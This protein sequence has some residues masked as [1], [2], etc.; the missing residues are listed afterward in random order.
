MAD[1]NLS[2]AI[3]LQ[4]ADKAV[5]N[6]KKEIQKGF[7][8]PLEIDSIGAAKKAIKK[9]QK[10]ADNT[11]IVVP[12]T[13]KN[14]KAKDQYE[15]IKKKLKPIQLDVA[16]DPKSVRANITTAKLNEILGAKKVKVLV[17]A[18]FDKASAKKLKSIENNINTLTKQAE[19]LQAVLDKAN[20]ASSTGP[21][22]SA[23]QPKGS[24]TKV[25]TE[26]KEEI[27]DLLNTT[28]KL[29]ILNN[30]IFGGSKSFGGGFFQFATKEING[31][32]VQLNKLS[33]GT[34]GLDLLAQKF[35]GLDGQSKGNLLNSLKTLFKGYSDLDIQQKKVVETGKK[36]GPSFN[37]KP[38][39]DLIKQAKQEIGKLFLAFD[40]ADPQTFAISMNSSL[41]KAR[42]GVSE[43]VGSSRRDIKDYE[44]LLSQLSQKQASALAAKARPETI[45]EIQN[46]IDHVKTEKI[47]GKSTESIKGGGTFQA[48]NALTG[49]FK[50]VDI[51]A[52]R[53]GASIDSVISKVSKGELKNSAIGKIL[54]L[55]GGTKSIG[56]SAGA[57]IA[58]TTDPRDI[59]KIKVGAQQDANAL[60]QR[61]DGVNRQFKR[62][63]SQIAQFEA[64]NFDG[65]AKS[66]KGFYSQFIKLAK[67]GTSIDDI[68]LAITKR[69]AQAVNVKGLDVKVNTAIKQIDRLKYA[70]NSSPTEDTIGAKK[71]LD[72]LESE[73]KLRKGKFANLTPEKLNTNLANGIFDIRA[74]Q[75]FNE[76]VD[77]TASKLR[78]IGD[79]NENL[80]VGQIY[81]KHA[82]EFEN[83]AKKIAGNSDNIGQKLRQLKNTADDT[84]IK[85]KFDAEGGFLGSVAKSA[86][87][88]TK[89]L[90]AFLVL[91]QGLYTVQAFLTSA[92]SDALKIDKEF[93]RLEQVFNKDFSGT[94]LEKTLTSVNKQILNLGKSLGVSTLEVA[95][96]AQTLAQAGIAGR[97]LEKLLGTISKSQLGP[98]FGNAGE[99]A[100]AT[101]AI[102]N[103]FKLSAEGV[104]AALGGINRVSAKYAVEAKGI[105]EAVRRAGG[106]F[107]TGGD[108]IASFTAAFT[109]VKQKTREADE[110][111]STGLRNVAQRLQTSKVQEKLKS[112]LG[113]DLVENGEFIGFERSIE[114]IGSAL[115]RLGATS[116]SPLFSQIRELIGGARQGGRVTPLL[117]DYKDFS[118]I[119]DQFSKGANSIEED[120]TTAF[121]SIE[122]K[123]QRAK[124]AIEALYVEL[125]R[126][127]FVTSL[128]EAFVQVTQFAT[129][130]LSVLNSV[131]GAILAI[132]AAA[133]V[134]SNSRFIGQALVSQIIPRTS[135]F[136]KN[137]GGK[138]PGRGPNKDSLLAALTPGEF[139]VSREATD[140][141]GEGFL[142]KINNRQF[143]RGGVVGFNKGGFTDKIRDVQGQIAVKTKEVANQGS[144][145]PKEL[146][147]ELSLLRRTLLSLMKQEQGLQAS[148]DTSAKVYDTSKVN[149]GAGGAN[150]A[151]AS[152][153]RNKSVIPAT[154]SR[155]T[156]E[157][158]VGDIGDH[159][160]ARSTFFDPSFVPKKT[161]SLA[162]V[163]LTAKLPTKA[164]GDLGKTVIS[165][166]GGLI[167]LVTGFAAVQGVLGQFGGGL[168]ELVTA[169]ASA[170]FS[171]YTFA[172]AGQAITFAK[173]ALGAGSKAIK[174]A[175]G[176]AVAAQFAEGNG[177]RVAAA[178]AYKASRVV[179]PGTGP[180]LDTASIIAKV[181]SAPRLPSAIGAGGRSAGAL[182]NSALA[183]QGTTISSAVKAFAGSAK[184]YASGLKAA[185]GGFNLA[186]IAVGLF[187]GAMSYF[188]DSME[189]AGREGAVTAKTLEES[190]SAASKRRFGESTKGAASL[191]GKVGAGAA[192]GG[193]LGSVVPVVGTAIGA[194]G[195]ALAAGLLHFGDDISEMFKGTLPQI[196]QLGVNIKSGV[197]SLFDNISDAL[198]VASENFKGGSFTD[199]I[200]SVS[201]L[202]NVDTYTG[203]G[204]GATYGDKILD[205]Q[206]KKDDLDFRTRQVA[207]RFVSDRNAKNPQ[208]FTNENLKDV[209]DQGLYGV[210]LLKGVREKKGQSFNFADFAEKDQEKIKDSLQLVA[211]AYREAGPKNRQ[212]ILAAYE[213]EG[214]DIK[215][216]A[217]EVGIEIDSAGDDMKHAFDELSSFFA[218]MRNAVELSSARLSGIEGAIAQFSDP[219]K[220][221]FAPDQLFDIL[222]S[223]I[224][225]SKLG[226]GNTFNAGAQRAEGL[227]NQ[228]DPRLAAAGNFE[229]QGRRAARNTAIAINSGAAPQLKKADEGNIDSFLG[230]AFSAGNGGNAD[231]DQ[232]FGKFL[233]SKSADDKSKL[234]YADG[235]GI[236]INQNEI[237]NLFKEFADT[238]ENGALEEIKR[239]NTVSKQFADEY[240]SQLAQRF[241]LEGEAIGLLQS[242]VE[243]RKSI[244]E[245]GNRARGLTGDALAGA[246]KGQAAAS[247]SQRLGLA[248]RGTGL[249]GNANAGQLQAALL[250]SQQ[251]QRNAGV[252]AQQGGGG[253]AAIVK[254]EAE[255]QAAETERQNRIRS[256][257][258]LLAGD[259]DSFTHAMNEFERASQKAAASS[260]FLSDALLGSDDQMHQSILGIQ[261]MA[262]I[263]EAYRKGG[264]G[265]A[266][267]TL[268]TFSEDAR[269]ALQARAGSSEENQ[270]AFNKAVGIS[271]NIQA[272]PE[273]AAAQGAVQ[274]Q[275]E[276]NNALVAGINNNVVALATN[277]ANMEKF[278]A[279]QFANTQ[280]IV[281]Q[282]EASAKALVG[283]IANLPQTIQHEGNINVNITGAAGLETLQKGISDYV[284]QMI[285]RDIEKLTNKLVENNAGLNR[286]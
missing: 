196:H 80:G 228:F 85:A 106:V 195:G 84:L 58:G 199:K 78:N 236:T 151:Y 152:F 116:K 137:N 38:Q 156:K 176:K 69:I 208:Q 27:E 53:A 134:L 210:G 164:F 66:L 82:A 79:A 136:G 255:I 86:G 71:A 129:R 273:A 74:A 75:R 94:K 171:M 258:Q 198:F 42:D 41:K 158:F 170:A 282:A 187:T 36:L 123:I 283:Q 28:K 231:L 268:S 67:S 145:A 174:G 280:Q 229:I 14:A 165:T 112:A 139:V 32:I 211:D 68:D 201:N 40:S 22:I 87:L 57:K 77:A 260:K 251:R 62:L 278:Y 270:A 277:T 252:I 25:V 162:S 237:N 61:V 90:A 64:A 202:Y 257:L 95:N 23:I 184:T 49:Q 73:L 140:M 209:K 244:D 173:N 5:A 101:I 35:E 47:S 65:A 30:Q 119:K 83:A 214:V 235:D 55:E 197:S 93:V 230:Q 46:L 3:S 225:P 33:G 274:Q 131:P 143:N 177:A 146:I 218:K 100:E 213:Q 206:K 241:A 233:A 45:K 150:D 243:K 54:N 207:R 135:I 220:Q 286:P 130:M 107:S 60:V 108:D 115:E 190:R 163:A 113:I 117:Q 9:A 149:T 120:V 248:L 219:S 169:M 271:S 21:V 167:A 148:V 59:E 147:N 76:A 17:E 51:A 114:R 247:D 284:Q 124:S 43:F 103:Q 125:V 182:A 224:D 238:L 262:K 10:D 1:F 8:V 265:A 138:I 276:A 81:S 249:G 121:Q 122:N 204:V 161:K 168:T 200:K 155:A 166:R 179:L 11:P 222:K 245:I 153:R 29:S 96:A 217:R 63:R 264:V 160:S 56:A 157:A 254:R 127:K 111:I 275:M 180:A 240:K 172:R 24:S 16:F 223:G 267:Q 183:K 70:L 250:A 212:L 92:F 232:A 50:Y 181:K 285:N 269:Q 141:Y 4:L 159:S 37:I 216:V 13:F 126:S 221:N 246:Q 234:A 175:T 98:S 259:T 88:A 279:A 281:Q 142:D 26:A 263:Q 97:D 31:L 52:Q 132:G 191:L 2:A 102:F 20:T 118:T 272:G 15:E 186:A 205:S 104:Q 34:K 239:I 19:K 192:V 44:R 144:S 194:I 99:T 193:S 18:D 185:I 133:K 266:Q 7:N 48:I 227:A 39:L 128:V 226:F 256:G 261:A 154:S 178:N 110:A 188:V 89:R 6:L 253:A 109:L 242:N 91:A 215:A 12:V 203:G 105:T 72:D 189:T